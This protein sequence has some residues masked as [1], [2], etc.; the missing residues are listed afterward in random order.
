MPKGLKSLAA[1]AL[2]VVFCTSGCPIGSP[3]QP[4]EDSSVYR[5]AAQ[6]ALVDGSAD[7]PDAAPPEVQHISAVD[8]YEDEI[9]YRMG[10]WF[11]D[12]RPPGEYLVSFIPRANNLPEADLWDGQGLVNGGQALLTL[13]QVHDLPVFF[14]HH[15]ASQATVE[16]IA[17]AALGIGYSDVWV[18]DG[19]IEA[20]RA[21]NYYEDIT[22]AG[23]ETYH[24][25]IPANEYIVDTMDATYYEDEGHITG[26]PNLDTLFW[27]D[28][29]AKQ[30]VNNGQALLNLIPCTATTIIFYC[31]NQACH[32]S[33]E[34]A[35]GIRLLSCYD[36]ATILHFAQGLERWI[37]NSNPVSCCTD[38]NG[39]APN[40]TCTCP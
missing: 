13:I 4:D 28:G 5:D 24:Y 26:A 14:Y 1:F 27:Y 7:V 17:E 15:A 34:A 30:L 6:D 25:P 35:V 39:P 38:P 33:T 36:N 11:L 16:A 9:P 31:V 18:L 8:L 12:L 32:S 19:G 40:P 3:N 2:M 23:V 22:V 21:Q 20:W 29:G 10:Q 37:A